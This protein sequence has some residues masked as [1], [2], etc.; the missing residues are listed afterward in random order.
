VI[1]R[2]PFLCGVNTARAGFLDTTGSTTSVTCP[3]W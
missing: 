3:S 1:L 2:N